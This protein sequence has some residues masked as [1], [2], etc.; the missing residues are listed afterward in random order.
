MA[1]T[2]GASAGR[3]SAGDAGAAG[4]AGVAAAG[5]KAGVVRVMRRKIGGDGASAQTQRKSVESPDRA[6]PATTTGS[7]DVARRSSWGGRRADT[8]AASSDRPHSAAAATSGSATLLAPPSPSPTPS[9]DL[10]LANP[11]TRSLSLTAQKP[12]VPPRSPASTSAPA[13][14]PASP[15][16]PSTPSRSAVLHA[17]PLSPVVPRP[18]MAHEIVARP[19]SAGAISTAGPKTGQLGRARSAEP[20]SSTSPPPTSPTS[21]TESRSFFPLPTTKAASFSLASSYSPSPSDARLRSLSPPSDPLPPLSTSPSPTPR[22]TTTSPSPNPPSLAPLAPISATAP[23][24]DL[25]FSPFGSQS[26][27]LSAA[28]RAISPPSPSTTTTSSATLLADF[29]H[30]NPLDSSFPPHEHSHSEEAE[31]DND[32]PSS[33]S[34]S[35]SPP[36]PSTPLTPLTPLWIPFIDPNKRLPAKPGRTSVTPSP[37]PD[38]HPRPPTHA[39]RRRPSGLAKDNPWAGGTI[40]P[41]PVPQC[42][43]CFPCG[44]SGGMGVSPRWV[45]RWRASRTAR[46]ATVVALLALLGIVVGLGVAFGRGSSSLPTTSTPLPVSPPVVPPSSLPSPVPGSPSAT[47]A[48]AVATPPPSLQSMGTRAANI[49]D[50]GTGGLVALTFNGALSPHTPRVRQ[51]LSSYNATA[52][53][54]VVGKTNWTDLAGVGVG[55]EVK[56]IVAEGH[57]VAS[58]GWSHCDFGTGACNLTQEVDVTSD[59]LATYLGKRPTYWR[60]PYN[61]STTEATSYLLSRSYHIVTSAIDTQDLTRYP[62]IYNATAT[63]ADLVPG[64][65]SAPSMVAQALDLG[66]LSVNS[67]VVQMYETIPGYEDAVEGVLKEVTS[68]GY[69]FVTVAQCFGDASGGYA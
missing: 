12:S 38:A 40:L 27:A 51:L 11:P 32:H 18:W 30:H 9:L 48:P 69:V 10:H 22:G 65:P 5:D 3:G 1:G 2:D 24:L 26:P 16:S 63:T 33:P 66:A 49:Y 44:G 28:A 47:S 55:D 56:R 21:P 53:F 6:E 46:A 8:A 31:A 42:F 50:C 41:S 35:P 14:A 52:T 36:P 67:Y 59:L 57:Q 20:T 17:L 45:D 25:S 4:V 62:P 19:H 61:R 68:R 29:T 58:M 13:P 7:P 54:F 15:T 34:P 43:P 39:P 64:L 60:F 23:T 37:T